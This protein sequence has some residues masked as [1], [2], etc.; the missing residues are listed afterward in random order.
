[1]NHSFE[2][3][4]VKEIAGVVFRPGWL[5]IREA[6][7]L[8]YKSENQVSRITGEPFKDGLLKGRVEMMREII[9]FLESIEQ[10]AKHEEDMG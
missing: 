7:E 4:E 8:H 1:M 3:G 10:L 2:V 9:A 6:L 5:H